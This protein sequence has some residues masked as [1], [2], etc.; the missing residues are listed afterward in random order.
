VIVLVQDGRRQIGEGAT[1]MTRMWMIRAERK[2]QLYEDFK[3]KSRG[4]WM[5]S[6]G[7]VIKPN[8]QRC[9]CQRG[10]ETLPDAH[11]QWQ[12]M[13]TRQLYRFRSE[14][15]EGDR[16]VTYDPERRVYL[17]GTV[18]GPYRFD[19]LIAEEDPN[20]ARSLGMAR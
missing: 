16:V 10:R 12:R 17:L 4:H 6:D 2:G 5:G 8:D 13:S 1:S 14:I 7:L 15:A 9:D 20:F 18:S 3:T 19:T 11:P